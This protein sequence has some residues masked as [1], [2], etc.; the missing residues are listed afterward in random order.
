[1]KKPAPFGRRPAWCYHRAWSI[2][3]YQV[4]INRRR[5]ATRRRLVS[6]G[7]IA[8]LI[9][10]RQR[11]ARQRTPTSGVPGRSW[12]WRPLPAISQTMCLRGMPQGKNGAVERPH[13]EA[14]PLKTP[15]FRGFAV[16]GTARSRNCQSSAPRPEGS[17][18]GGDLLRLVKKRVREYPALVAVAYHKVHFAN[19][20]S[21]ESGTRAVVFVLQQ[22][23]PGKVYINIVSRSW[24][25]LRK[26]C[27]ANR[28]CRLS[29]CR[30]WFRAQGTVH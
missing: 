16:Y 4:S 24:G 9:R 10:E 15:E 19:Q 3:H 13:G 27:C 23:L 7:T 12:R 5:V 6:G 17:E 11:Q 20:P 2:P 8:R 28:L 30:R 14:I 21:R 25:G 22:S 26:P 18:K 29:P 1:M